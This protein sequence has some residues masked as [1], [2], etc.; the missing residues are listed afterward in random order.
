MILSGALNLRQMNSRDAQN[1]INNRSYQDH[2]N[3]TTSNRTRL[4][5]NVDRAQDNTDRTAELAQAKF[6]QIKTKYTSDLKNENVDNTLAEKRYQ[7]DLRKLD[8]G[9]GAVQQGQYF[10]NPQG[11]LEFFNKGDNPPN[12]YTKPGDPNIRAISAAVLQTKNMNT[13]ERLS[14]YERGA[15]EGLSSAGLAM[16]DAK[17]EQAKELFN[18]ESPDFKII[19]GTVPGEYWGTNPGW[20]KVPKG[21]VPKVSGAGPGNL[22]NGNAAFKNSTQQPIP[23]IDTQA[24]YDQLVVGSK[25]VDAQDGK[26]YIRK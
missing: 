22:G 21:E 5:N 20:E 12:N 16:D 17:R 4:Q 10:K 9:V 14:V 19:W 1:R 25:Y 15:L 2:T 24:E 7:L 13:R 6:D 8:E 3:A 26:T 11:G 18:A 23:T